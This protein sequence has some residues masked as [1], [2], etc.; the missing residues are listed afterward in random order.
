MA[1]FPRDQELLQRDLSF[2]NICFRCHFSIYIQLCIFRDSM[3]VCMEENNLK[4][5]LA[6]NIRLKFNFISR[7]VVDSLHRIISSIST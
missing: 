4:I 7:F 1:L 6:L 2:V 5:S 3:Y